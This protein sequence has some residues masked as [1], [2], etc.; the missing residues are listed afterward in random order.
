LPFVAALT[1][2]EIKQIALQQEAKPTGCELYHPVSTVAKDGLKKTLNP[3]DV[4][5]LL[6]VALAPGSGSDRDALSRAASLIIG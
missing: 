4:L 2:E 1:T 3:K 5:A 6:K